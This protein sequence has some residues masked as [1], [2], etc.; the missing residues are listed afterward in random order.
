MLLRQGHP[1]ARS[2]KG[3]EAL[4]RLDFILVAS[5]AEP[6]RAL[7]LLGLQPRIRLTLPHF[8]VVPAILA[9]TD[10]AVILPL[11]PARRFAARHDLQVLEPDL[12][13]PPFQVAMHWTLRS[14]HDPGHR[15]LRDAALRMHFENVAAPRRRQRVS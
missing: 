8:M 14:T 2:L 1:L 7:H 11:R 13:L 12:G 6:A 10:L 15:W 3:R 4:D 5:H 9:A